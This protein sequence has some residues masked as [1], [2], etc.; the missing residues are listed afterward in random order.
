M[1]G[2]VYDVHRNTVRS[3]SHCAL[4]L[5]GTEKSAVHRDRP[6]MLSELKPAITV[7]IRNI[8]QADLQKVFV[9][10]IK[11]VQACIDTRGYHFQHLL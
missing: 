9:N 1:L 2:F 4:R 3:K 5:W 10:K 8:S 7:F 11:W 6:H